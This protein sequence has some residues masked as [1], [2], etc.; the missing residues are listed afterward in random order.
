VLSLAAGMLTSTCELETNNK[1][2]N[3]GSFWMDQNRP[4]KTMLHTNQFSKNNAFPEEAPSRQP[5]TQEHQG[6]QLPRHEHAQSIL[7]ATWSP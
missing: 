7:E 1:G 2:R 6:T 3:T 4:K 5:L